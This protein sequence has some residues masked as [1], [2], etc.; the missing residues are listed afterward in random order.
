MLVNPANQKVVTRIAE[1]LLESICAPIEYKGHLLKVG[2]S[3]GVK[4]VGV[5]ERDATRVLKSA[6]TAMY[7]AKKAGK[8]QAILM[9]CELQEDSLNRNVK[10][11]N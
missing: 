11:L 1:Q 3:I 6:D 7:Q 2:V 4:L 10:A 9:G 8:G 5:N